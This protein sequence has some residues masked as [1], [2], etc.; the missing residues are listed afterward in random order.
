MAKTKKKTV[1][2][3]EKVSM[4]YTMTR[5]KYALDPSVCQQ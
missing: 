4:V 5:E 3:I 1:D 2:K